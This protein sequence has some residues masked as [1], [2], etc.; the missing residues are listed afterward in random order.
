MYLIA[1][2][3][4]SK[5]IRSLRK[6]RKRRRTRL[7]RRIMKSLKE[8]RAKM[9]RK[10]KKR[11]MWLPPLRSSMRRSLKLQGSENLQVI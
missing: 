8:K 9:M 1:S 3:T 10:R 4:A 5:K 6:R 2:W 11:K 7:L